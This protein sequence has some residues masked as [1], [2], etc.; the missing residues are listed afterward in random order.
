[1]SPYLQ[2]FTEPRN[3]IPRNRFCMAGNRFLG[4]LKGSQIRDTV[5]KGGYGGLG[6]RQINPCRKDPLKVNYFRLPYFAFPSMSLIFLR[7]GLSNYFLRRQRRNGLKREGLSP[8]KKKKDKLQHKTRIHD[9]R[10]RLSE[11]SAAVNAPCLHFILFFL[12]TILIVFFL[13]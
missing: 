12:S 10:K 5:C 7:D 3:S 8:R 11:D 9:R 13:A 6:L 4:S 1:M 2:T